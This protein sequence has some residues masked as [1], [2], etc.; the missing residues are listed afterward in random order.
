M[1]SADPAAMWKGTQFLT[2]RAVG[3][4]LGAIETMAGFEDG[5]WRLYG[6]KWFCSHADA[7]V[8]LLLA[9]PEGAPAGTEGLALFALPR[10]LEDGRRNAYRIVRLKD[11]LGT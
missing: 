4:D 5:E 7:D 9:R 2:E 8:A 3:S 11:K 6:D 10:R 1:L